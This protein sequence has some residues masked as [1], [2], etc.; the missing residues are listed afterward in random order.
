[1]SLASRMRRYLGINVLRVLQREL[2]TAAQGYAALGYAGH[3]QCARNIECRVL[4]EQEALQFSNDPQLE[5]TPAWV[6][7]AYAAG[8]VCI[9]A[10]EGGRLIGYTWLAFGV[11]RYASGVSVRFDARFR[12]SYKSFVRPEFRGQRIAQALHALADQPDLRR[13]RSH[14][15][16]FVEIDNHPSRAALERAG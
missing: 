4:S 15:L 7:N 5:L 6:C 3:P 2:G 11:T 12:Y 1:M 8:G 10:I 16:N 9:G 14:A 13:G